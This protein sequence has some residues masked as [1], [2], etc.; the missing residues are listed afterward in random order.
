M[1]ETAVVD[2]APGSGSGLRRT[3]ASVREGAGRWLKTAAGLAVLGY[4]GLALAKSFVLPVS[5]EA[6]VAGSVTTL[7]AP[8]DGVLGL[9][10]VELG[11]IVKA[12]HRLAEIRNPWEDDGLVRDLQNRLAVVEAELGTLEPQSAALEA[13]ADGLRRGASLYQLQRVNQL[14]S[15]LAEARARLEADKAQE[16]LGRERHARATALFEQG[17]ASQEEVAQAERDRRVAEQ[18]LEATTRSIEALAGQQESAR[19][20]VNVDAGGMGADRP[21]SRQRLDEVSLELIRVRQRTEAQSRVRDALKAELARAQQRFDQL[22]SAA[23]SAVRPGRVWR[24]HAADGAYV[25]RGQPVLSVLDCDVGLVAATVKERVFDDLKIGGAATFELDGRKLRGRIV[26]LEGLTKAAHDDL[27]V[28]PGLVG[29]RDP[30]PTSAD[31]YRVT[32]SVPDLRKP[33]YDDCAV[34]RSGDVTFE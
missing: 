1:T 16:A 6:V 21:Y 24:V 27:V 25:N 12:E 31:P 14:N 19:Q 5:S 17:V 32:I 33:P 26:Q 22:S 7:R 15:L 11:A 9:K 30:I 18:S 28:A 29:Q 34:G 10:G 13:L 20:G 8:I 2:A 4:A 3:L 23:L